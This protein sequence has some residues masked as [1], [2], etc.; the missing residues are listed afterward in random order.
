MSTDRRQHF[1][2]R[3]FLKIAAEAMGAAGLAALAL[4][5]GS[6]ADRPLPP[7]LRSSV[8][9]AYAFLARMMDLYATGALLRLAQSYVPTPALDLA[10]TAFTYD[11]ALAIV[12]YLERGREDDVQRARLL[13]DSLLYAQDH[14]PEFSDGRLRDAYGADPFVLSNGSVKVAYYFGQGGSATGNQAWGGMALAQLY[15][16]TGDSRYL[17]GA[18]RLGNWIQRN[19][20][21]SRGAGGYTGGIAADQSRL[22]WKS[23]EHNI[24]AWALFT[25]LSHL[26]HDSTWTDRANHA[27]E[28]VRSMW[29][30]DGGFFWTGT[31]TDG[32]TTNL[33]PIPED[34]QSW[35]YLALRDRAYEGSLDWVERALA[36]SDGPF[37]GVSFSS[38]DTSGVWFE[39]T[40]HMAAA[41]LSRHSPGDRAAAGRYLASIALAQT[42]AP[43]A[44]GEGIVAASHDGLQTGFGYAYFA[45][46][47]VGTTS[48][49]CI[50]AQGGDPFVL[51]GGRRL[52][53]AL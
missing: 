20:S 9:R 28:F 37:E 2:R 32:V 33:S 14:D 15:F 3:G 13:G 5:G 39:G 34:A 52:G 47:H 53:T 21:D 12:A 42:S 31:G 44:D 23:T 49:Y 50:A 1:T 8:D 36:A 43:N 16:R 4:R 17:A 38:A 27:L 26:T 45:S 29:S 22:T 25:M 24:D 51:R 10:D 48:W 19:T 40:G 7:D 41:L 35:S 11:N 46:P 18:L 30:P 6:R